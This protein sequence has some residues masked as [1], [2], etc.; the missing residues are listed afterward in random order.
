[1]HNRS[2]NPHIKLPD[3][4][5]PKICHMVSPSWTITPRGSIQIADLDKWRGV[6]VGQAELCQLPTGGSHVLFYGMN[7]NHPRT[8]RSPAVRSS[9]QC[10][11]CARKG[12]KAAG[13]AIQV[14]ITVVCFVNSCLSVDGNKYW[15]WWY[16]LVLRWHVI[17]VIISI[18][19]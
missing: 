11:V 13:V 18:C 3:L 6:A 9:K 12:G 16:A 7:V 5:G 15:F 19:R 4:T 8:G 10:P 2:R 17:F 1:M 14:Q